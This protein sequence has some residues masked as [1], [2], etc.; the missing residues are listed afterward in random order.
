MSLKKSGEW[1][2][3]MVRI[4]IGRVG[5][6]VNPIGEDGPGRDVECGDRRLCL[7][8]AI[9]TTPVLKALAKIN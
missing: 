8:S 6:R 9:V 4:G 5:R 1:E 7:I 2:R 3:R